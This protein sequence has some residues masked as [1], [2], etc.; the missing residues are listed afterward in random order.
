MIQTVTKL[1]D[2]M[3]ATIDEL[4]ASGEFKSRSDVVRQSVDSFLSEVRR[5]KIGEAISD[6][7]RRVPD[8]G[9]ESALAIAVATAMILEEPW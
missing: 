3:V 6:G 2:E 4:V 8:T 5:R 7:Y 1:D 9:D